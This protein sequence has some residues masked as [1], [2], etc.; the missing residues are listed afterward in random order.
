MSRG[1]TE[2]MLSKEGYE[3]RPYGWKKLLSEESWEIILLPGKDTASGMDEK[4]LGKFRL[5]DHPNLVWE[6][7]NH[8]GYFDGT[9]DGEFTLL[10][11]FLYTDN[12]VIQNNYKKDDMFYSVYPSGIGRFHTLKNISNETIKLLIHCKINY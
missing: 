5:R 9:G 1:E 12:K 2:E 6:K 3:G 7:V 10:Y 4:I 8:L 11:M